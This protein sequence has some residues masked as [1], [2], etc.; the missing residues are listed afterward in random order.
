[1]NVALSELPDFTFAPGKARPPH[2]SAGIIIAPSLRY[3]E[4]AYFD[5][6]TAR[7]GELICEM[8]IPSTW[9]LAPPRRE[10]TSR[11]LF[12]QHFDPVLPGGRSWD[13]AKERAAEPSRYVNAMRRTSRRASSPGKS[14]RR[15]T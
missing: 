8:L 9:I 7:L 10:S 14:S 11:S 2:H 12:C 1:M 4:R 5:A 15:S 3:M 13:D 6:R